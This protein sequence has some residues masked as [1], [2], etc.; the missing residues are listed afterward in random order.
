MTPPAQTSLYG[1]GVCTHEGIGQP[2]C[3]TCDPDRHRVAGRFKHLIGELT[4]ALEDISFER[5]W[6]DNLELVDRVKTLLAKP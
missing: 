2:G 4:T 3:N 6:R 1:W 5:D